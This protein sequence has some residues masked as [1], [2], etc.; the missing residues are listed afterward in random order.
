MPAFLALALAMFAA[1]SSSGAAADPAPSAVEPP[2]NPQPDPLRKRI[3]RRKEYGPFFE[4]EPPSDTAHNSSLQRGKRPMLSLG[5]GTF[6]FV[7]GTYCKSALLASAG[8]AT[9]LRVPASNVGPDMPYSQFSVHA[10]LVVRPLMWRGH[11]W[12]P[13]GLGAMASWSRGTG[14]VTVQGDAMNQDVQSTRRTDAFRIGVHNQVWLS[15]KAHGLHLDLTV[16]AVRSE[17]L[18]SGV[19][20]WGTHAELGVSAGGWATLFAGGDFLDRDARIFLGMRAHGIAA[21]P[22][23][24]I[25]LA[26]M[27]IGGAL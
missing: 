11:A 20:L 3:A 26:G 4:A 14:A 22:L 18:T 2:S 13:W 10:G 8:V 21:A 7:D 23:I 27:A 5:D 17:V 24:A 6:C 19:P 16:G 25:A 9:G 12:H 15:R 1:P